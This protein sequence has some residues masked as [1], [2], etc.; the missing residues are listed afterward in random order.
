[1]PLNMMIS[2]NFT[3]VCDKHGAVSTD[4]LKRNVT[5]PALEGLQLRV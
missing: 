4:A 3:N 5:V 1:M 2:F